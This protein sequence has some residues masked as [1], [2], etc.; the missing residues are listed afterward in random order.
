MTI[1]LALVAGLVLGY[2]PS[3]GAISAFTAPCVALIRRPPQLNLLRAYLLTLLIAI[4]LVQ[5]DDR[6]R[7]DNALGS[8]LGLAG[9]PRRRPRF[10]RRHG[11][12]RYL[13]DRHLL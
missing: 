6:P 10:R 11:N 2:L 4:P 7:L 9:E 13:R 1:L 3:K 8:A 12:R 5:G